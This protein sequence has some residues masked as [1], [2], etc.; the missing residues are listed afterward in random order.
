MQVVK[1]E[2]E[3]DLLVIELTDKTAV[4]CGLIF[5]AAGR[6]ADSSYGFNEVMSQCLNGFQKEYCVKTK[7]IALD[8]K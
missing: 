5:S 8:L 6:L 7:L 4:D 2:R 1:Q 3:R